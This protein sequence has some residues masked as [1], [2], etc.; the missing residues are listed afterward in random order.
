MSKRA[1]LSHFHLPRLQPS[2]AARIKPGNICLAAPSLRY[3]KDHGH[4]F[5]T[6]IRTSIMPTPVKD[7]LARLYI[8]STTLPRLTPATR[9]SASQVHQPRN[10]IPFV[11]TRVHRARLQRHGRL[12]VHRVGRVEVPR[13]S[14]PVRAN[15]PE[16]VLYVV[17]ERARA[18]HRAAA[19]RQEVLRAPRLSRPRRVREVAVAPRLQVAAPAGLAPVESINFY[20][21]ASPALSSPT[22]TFTLSKKQSKHAAPYK[23]MSYRQLV[24]KRNRPRQRPRISPVCRGRARTRK[25]SGSRPPPRS[26]PRTAAFPSSASARSRSSPALANGGTS[27]SSAS[28]VHQLLLARLARAELADSDLHTEQEAVQA[29]SSVQTHEL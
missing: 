11:H 27:R 9:P 17:G 29:C 3:R 26:A 7:S 19:R 20:L 4:D 6:N 23:R 12:G 2:L 8:T 10:S 28:Q 15:A 14:W 24:K 13:C 25:P 22:A 18:V 5:S 1:S 21:L 16:L